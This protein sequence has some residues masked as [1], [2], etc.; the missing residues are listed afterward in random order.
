MKER[1]YT[2]VADALRARG[3]GEITFAVEYPSDRTRGDFSVNAALVAAKKL[4]KKP[5]ELASELSEILVD[6]LGKD[7]RAVKIAEP[8]FINITLSSSAL[9]GQLE[10][11]RAAGEEWGSGNAQKEKRVIIEYG[12]P[13]PFKE[14][15]IGHLVGTIVGE[16]L[17]RLI[18]NTGA[19]VARDTFGG[20]VGPHV[21]KALWGLRTAGNTEPANASEVGRAYAHGARAYE[22]SEKAKTEI[23]ALNVMLYETLAAGEH[24]ETLSEDERKLL[25]TWRVGKSVSVEEFERLYLILGTH[26]DYAFYDSDT[27]KIGIEVV[28]DGVT[29]GVLE[30]SDGAIIYRGEKKGLHTL[31][32]ITS[33]GTPTYETKDIG[34]AFLKETR[35]PSDWSIIITAAEQIGHFKVLLAALGDIAPLLAK[36]TEHLA[37]G[38]LQLTTG[39]MSSRSGNV[40]TAAALI[41]EV[42]ARAMQKND[43]PV[44]ARQ[45]AVAAVKYMVLR[46]ALGADILFDPEQS[47]SFEGDSGPYLQYSLVRARSVLRGAK[48]AGKSAAEAL[49][50]DA[51][52]EPY[53][54]TR[55]LTRF[56]ES[57]ARAASARAPNILTTYL[58]E[59]AGAWNSFYAKE[60]ILG[61]E[62]EAHKLALVQAFAQTMQN[63]LT[64]LGIPTP[65]KM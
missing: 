55:L 17:S 59:L 30:E 9:Y 5:R 54:I 10:R 31:V 61:G 8:G 63:G 2:V 1:I 51:P 16:A 34:L 27:T 13:N 65:E 26:F 18:E 14:M 25:E 47:L 62:H 44:V 43:D 3:A 21:A 41:E 45:V 29:K 4:G 60:R 58:T 35:W 38:F 40:I 49:A 52:P 23:D 48:E 7:A 37:H 11:A 53:G 42:V 22:E 39:K 57:A 6:K 36:K 46:Q 64:L 50:E 12:S 33:R 19:V 20:D 28:R 56:P 15:H 24:P 32:F